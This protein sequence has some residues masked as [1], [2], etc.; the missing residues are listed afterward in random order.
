M[1]RLAKMLWINRKIN[2][3]RVGIVFRFQDGPRRIVGRM[4]PSPEIVAGYAVRGL[5]D[6]DRGENPPLKLTPIKNVFRTPIIKQV[7]FA[8]RE[9]IVSPMNEVFQVARGQ[10]A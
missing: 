10:I 2:P 4:F 7:I 5:N 9:V 8:V 6:F 1:K 3:R